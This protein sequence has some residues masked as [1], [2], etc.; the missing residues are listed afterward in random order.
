L[1]LLTLFL[2]QLHCKMDNKESYCYKCEVSISSF[3]SSL[4]LLK[5]NNDMKQIDLETKFTSSRLLNSNKS[6]KQI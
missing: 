5:T 3:N 4:V 6:N 2:N 1:S